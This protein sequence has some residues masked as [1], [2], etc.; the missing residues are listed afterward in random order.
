MNWTNN[1]HA[2]C[3]WRNLLLYLSLF[4]FIYLIY[5]TELD[6]LF[7]EGLG[8]MS[9]FFY[10]PPVVQDIE[11]SQ[12]GVALDKQ[13]SLEQSCIYSL[14]MKSSSIIQGLINM[15]VSIYSDSEQIVFR[16]KIH[17]PPSVS[18]GSN[19]RPHLQEGEKVFLLGRPYLPKGNYRFVIENLNNSSSTQ[20]SNYTF[21][22]VGPRALQ[23]YCGEKP[24][25]VYLQEKGGNVRLVPSNRPVH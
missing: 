9:S 13:Y 2:C 6:Y 14:W 11:L 15:E 17:D 3:L 16:R 25:F 23:T 24:Q 12:P 10:G 21:I 4:S 20:N 8:Q 5:Q 1:S 19:G 22:A 7:E 18:K